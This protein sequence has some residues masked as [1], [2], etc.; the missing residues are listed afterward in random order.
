MRAD[1]RKHHTWWSPCHSFV[2]YPAP[3]ACK[4]DRGEDT[5]SAGGERGVP[6]ADSGREGGEPDG[7]IQRWSAHSGYA[8]VTTRTAAVRWLD[9]NRTDLDRGVSTS[10]N[11]A[12]SGV[13][14]MVAEL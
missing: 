14:D 9:A 10:M 7:L 8:D 4:G 1:L 12:L 13:V 11:R 5:W 6:P 3:G 2:P